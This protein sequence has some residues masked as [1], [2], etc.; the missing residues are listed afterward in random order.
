M[1]LIQLENLTTIYDTEVPVK[2]P[3]EASANLFSILL[4]KKKVSLGDFLK[5]CMKESRKYDIGISWPDF[6]VL[7]AKEFS[8][9]NQV[10]RPDIWKDRMFILSLLSSFI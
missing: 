5:V 9:L 8:I 2:W 7:A 3:T 4:Q 6:C 10:Q 1:Y